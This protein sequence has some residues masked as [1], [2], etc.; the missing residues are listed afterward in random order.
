MPSAPAPRLAKPMSPPEAVHLHVHSEYSL[1]DGACNIDSLAERAAAFGQ[2]ALGLTDHGV[3]NGAVELYKACKKNGI[4][5]IVGL[6]AYL[7]DD[8]TSEAIKFERNHLT[9]LAHD[10]DG[11]RNLVKLTSAGF[12][13]GYKRGKPNV[14]MDLLAKHSQGVIALTGCLASRFCRRLVEDNPGEARAHVDQLLNVFGPENVYFEVQQNGIADQAKANDGIVR[15][16]REVGRPLVGTADVHYLR[17]EDYHHHAALLCVQTKS[18]LQEPKLSFDTNEFY[19]KSNDEMADSFAGFPGAVESTLEIAE[20]CD[21]DIA[22]GKML[23]PR[24]P[25]PSGEDEGAYLRDLAME[26]LR[27]RYGDPLPAEAVER[28]EMELGVIDRM[29]FNAYFLIVWDFVKFA[30]DNGIAVGPGRGSAAGS[31]ASYALRITDV[32]PL[33]YDLLFERFLNAER[34]SMPD[35]DIDFSVK[36]RDRV[37]RYV[38]DKYGQ[39]SVAQI[40]TFGRM[41]PRAATRDAARVLGHDYGAGDRL[42]KLIP[43]PIMGRPPSFEDCLKPGEDLAREYADDPQARKIIDVA[44]GLEGTVR[45]SS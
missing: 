28:L 19:L 34:V 31:I 17:R 43:D 38:A 42:A 41:F 22:L 29:G 40:V 37:I 32:D 10:D 20:R 7:C 26:G 25:T 44:R 5:P 8:V 1:L 15:V 23:I 2:P 39:D 30:K 27:R 11:F 9:L 4:K 33:R 12:L 6:E 35:I 21:V 13:Q 36:G 18:T 45:N 3:M 16:A 14:D 24:Y